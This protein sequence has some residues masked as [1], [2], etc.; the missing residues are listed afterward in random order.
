MFWTVLI[1]LSPQPQ[2]LFN[3]DAQNSWITLTFQSMNI[4]FIFMPRNVS[5]IHEFC[6]KFVNSSDISDGEY[7]IYEKIV[8][9]I[10]I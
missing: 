6:A 9:N 4:R 8:N 3:S 7:K 1:R 2:H 5:V 10:D